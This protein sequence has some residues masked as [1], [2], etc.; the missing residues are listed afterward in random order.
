MPMILFYVKFFEK[1]QYAE[2]FLAGRLWMNDLGFFKRLED[3][4][5]RADRFEAP[6]SWYQPEQVEMRFGDLC[7]PSAD[8]AGPVSIQFNSHD[9]TNL[10]CLYAGTSGPFDTISDEN[11]EAI[12]D[13]LPVP[14]RC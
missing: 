1:L 3:A 6:S 5:G 7:I 14:A 9:N 8:L 12:R 11:I 13:S 10:F 2:D 4:S